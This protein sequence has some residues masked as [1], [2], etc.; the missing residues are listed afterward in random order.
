ME[1]EDLVVRVGSQEDLL[2]L[3][4][5]DAE[6]VAWVEVPLSLA[7]R[8]ELN[9]FSVDVLLHDPKAEA[10]QLYRLAG[11]REPNLPRLSIPNKPG[12][13]DAAA[14]GMALHFPI[15]LIPIQP[16]PEQMSE[17]EAVLERYLHDPNARQP[18]EPFNCALATLIKGDST[19]L[20]GAIEQD[21][22]IFRKE[23]PVPGLESPDTVTTRL[24]SLIADGAECAT[25][26]LSPWCAGWFKWPDP[27]Y[28]CSGV[29]KLFGQVEKAAEKLRADLAEA[30]E[31]GP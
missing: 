2:L 20:W 25:C 7:C 3:S 1:S 11:Q 14:V 24:E 27:S 21:P 31:V 6:R 22:A 26:S 13:A 15:R 5:L 29:R 16:P 12:F 4:T 28:D 19:T 8:R 10:S 17:L 23:P 9:D 30:L 18:V